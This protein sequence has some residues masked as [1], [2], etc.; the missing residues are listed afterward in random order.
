MSK[1]LMLFENAKVGDYVAVIFE[2][3]TI[4]ISIIQR[5]TKKMIVLAWG[6]RYWRGSGKRVDAR[7]RGHYAR[8]STKKEYD[9]WINRADG[10]RKKQE[11]E[12]Q[13]RNA[14]NAR[15]DVRILRAIV[16]EIEFHM[17]RI[18][19]LDIN[20]LRMA[21]RLLTLPKGHYLLSKLKEPVKT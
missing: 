16:N 11:A 9:A 8:P 4:L 3:S 5:V 7:A 6:N 10:H 14:Y 17:D 19:G 15:E 21:Y 18:L 12:E 20:R 1:N 13:R 2:E